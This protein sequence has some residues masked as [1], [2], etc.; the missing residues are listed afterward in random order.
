VKTDNGDSV[1]SMARIALVGLGTIGRGWA[2]LFAKAGFAVAAFDINAAAAAEARADVT[3]TLQELAA[4]GMLD[5]APAAAA[6]IEWTDSVAVAVAGA[7]L[8]QESVPERLQLKRTV[9][10]ELDRVAPADAILASSCSS[11]LPADL[12]SDLQRQER[13]LVAHPFNPPYLIPLVELLPTRLTSGR[14]LLAMRKLLLGIGQSPVIIHRALPGYVANRLQAA[15][16]NEAM[17]LVGA[18]VISA[19]DLDR[20][21]TQGLGRRWAFLGPFETMDLNADGGIASYARNF[22]HGYAEIGRDLRSGSPWSDE[23]IAAVVKS[24][25][26]QLDLQSLKA[27]REW[28]DRCLA[29]MR[30]QSQEEAEDSAP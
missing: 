27:R 3:N 15:L 4:Q 12:F 16:V 29:R 7:T 6:R 18:G 2:V 24:R 10:A 1:N 30:L 20:C 26:E 11:L 13:C 25:R 14:T 21:M 9:L 17:H 23:A 5:S 19:E 8:V 28:R 22:R